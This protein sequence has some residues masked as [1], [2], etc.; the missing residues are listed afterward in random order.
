MF[1]LV[2][3]LLIQIF[4]WPKSPTWR[5]LMNMK[6]S[7]QFQKICICIILKSAGESIIKWPILPIEHEFCNLIIYQNKLKACRHV[8]SVHFRLYHN[9]DINCPYK[10]ES[11]DFLDVDDK[12]Q[13]KSD[14]LIRL[15]GLKTLYIALKDVWLSWQQRK[16][17]A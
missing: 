2:L 7:N 13:Y 6:A 4:V 11:S 12:N 14:G 15:F 9:I 5:L 10:K 16:S 1:I 8:G 3:R 17:E